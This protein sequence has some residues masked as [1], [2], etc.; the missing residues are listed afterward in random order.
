M[1]T[2]T[3]TEAKT[4]L[5]SLVERVLAGEDVTIGRRGR[6]EVRLVAL[7]RRPGPRPLGSIILPDYWMSEDFDAP[8]DDV[9]DAF[10]PR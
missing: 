3:V 6:P 2:F 8:L 10:H 5:S 7:G 9:D 1:S 4:Q